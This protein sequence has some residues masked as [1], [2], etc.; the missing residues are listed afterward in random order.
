ML[1]SRSL[2]AT[3]KRFSR[4]IAWIRRKNLQTAKNCNAVFKISLP[5]QTCWGRPGGKRQLEKSGGSPAAR[6]HPE[7]PVAGV[8][9]SG[10]D[11]AAFVEGAVDGRGED[12]QARVM[13]VDVS[14]ALRGGHQVDQADLP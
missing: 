7:Q 13:R 6:S 3:I 12:G 8:A 1:A 11:E 5:V 10:H 9:E 2:S 4:L 14:D